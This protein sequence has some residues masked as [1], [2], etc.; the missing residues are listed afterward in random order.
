[1]VVSSVP[2]NLSYIESI[3]FLVHSQT[4]V[5]VSGFQEACCFLWHSKLPCMKCWVNDFSLFRPCSPGK[6]L[7]SQFSVFVNPTRLC[8]TL[9][10]KFMAFKKETKHHFNKKK[11]VV[12]FFF[13][14]FQGLCSTFLLANF[15]PNPC[16]LFG[17][18]KGLVAM[19]CW[20]GMLVLVLLQAIPQRWMG[21]TSIEIYRVL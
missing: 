12:L 8:F 2:R 7:Q 13:G 20:F 4:F 1:M 19:A 5:F 21:T 3:Q 6:N 15:P 18:L 16:L 11:G 10:M 9:W 17:G 14:I